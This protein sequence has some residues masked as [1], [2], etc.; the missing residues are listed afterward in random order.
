MP[1]MIAR[2]FF[3]LKMSFKEKG[4]SADDQELIKD[5]LNHLAR[6]ISP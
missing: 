6:S 4:C 2:Y 5:Q 1:R 3:C